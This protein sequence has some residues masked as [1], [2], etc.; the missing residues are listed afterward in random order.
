MIKIQINPIKQE[1]FVCY[2]Q[3]CSFKTYAD[4]YAEAEDVMMAH[5]DQKHK[6]GTDVLEITSNKG[7]L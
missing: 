1:V 2:C 7:Q 6:V 3:L 5:Y 4:S